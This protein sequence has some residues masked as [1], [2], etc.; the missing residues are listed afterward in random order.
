MNCVWEASV[1]DDASFLFKMDPLLLQN[2]KH[3]K[4]LSRASVQVHF[5]NGSVTLKI[6]FKHFQTESCSERNPPSRFVPRNNPQS[7]HH[8]FWFMCRLN[9]LSILQSVKCVSKLHFLWYQVFK[10]CKAPGPL[11]SRS[12]SA[13]CTLKCWTISCRQPWVLDLDFKLCSNLLRWT[14]VVFIFQFVMLTLQFTTKLNHILDL[15]SRTSN[16]NRR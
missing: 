4:C 11:Q 14:Y 16:S 2:K 1:R 5:L 8:L 7:F 6:N 10:H 13:C 9:L 3:I 12:C 15:S